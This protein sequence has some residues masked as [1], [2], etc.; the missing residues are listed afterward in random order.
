MLALDLSPGTENGI[1][2]RPPPDNLRF[3]ELKILHVRA[4][5]LTLDP[6]SNSGQ[7]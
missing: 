4:G 1:P 2:P 5:M 3:Q 6:E 7:A